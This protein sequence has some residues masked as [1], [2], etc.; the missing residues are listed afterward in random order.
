MI[1]I[2]RGC[3]V[4]ESDEDIRKCIDRAEQTNKLVS[5]IEIDKKS[6]N[7]FCYHSQITTQVST[8]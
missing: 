7:H 4:V 6:N 8:H 3:V 1:L 5:H 2:G